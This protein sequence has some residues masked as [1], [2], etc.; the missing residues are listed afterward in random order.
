MKLEHL[1]DKEVLSNLK[2]LIKRE[3]FFLNVS[4]VIIACDKDDELV[5]LYKQTMANADY[6][7][8]MEICIDKLILN[9]DKTITISSL[10]YCDYFYLSETKKRKIFLEEICVRMASDFNKGYGTLL[11]KYL[12]KVAVKS[13]ACQIRGLFV[14][15]YPGNK[16]R[17]RQF[18]LRNNFTLEHTDG[19]PETRIIKNSNKFSPLK[20]KTIKRIDFCLDTFK[21]HED[22]EIDI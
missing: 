8:S 12:Q 13:H 16:A 9:P 5:M 6:G 21:V 2:L 10:G 15:F 7:D 11:I 14:P 4:D 22:E 19:Y 18:Y 1:K 3:I 17:A 20:T